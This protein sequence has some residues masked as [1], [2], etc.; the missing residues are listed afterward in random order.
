MEESQLA[1]LGVRGG[2]IKVAD[3]TKDKLTPVGT[4]GRRRCC[5]GT[6]DAYEILAFRNKCDKILL[7]ISSFHSAIISFD[8]APTTMSLF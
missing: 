6:S 5:N 3:G 8:Q 4:F 7:S 2:G 1:A